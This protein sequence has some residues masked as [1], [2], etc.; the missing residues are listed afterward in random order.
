MPQEAEEFIPQAVDEDELS[1]DD[2]D[3]WNDDDDEGFAFCR[4]YVCGVVFVFLNPAEFCLFSDNDRF[5]GSEDDDDDYYGDDEYADDDDD[6]EE[7][8]L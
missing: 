6:E 7:I 3:D 4:C 5:F 1:G 2:D 8:E